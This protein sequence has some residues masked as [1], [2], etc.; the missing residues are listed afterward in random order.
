[1][2]EKNLKTLLKGL[3]LPDTILE[4]IEKPEFDVA[5]TVSAYNESQKAHY[6]DIIKNEIAPEI[7]DELSR[8][9]NGKWLGSLN[10]DLKKY[11]GVP[12]DEIKDLPVHEKLKLVKKKQDEAASKNPDSAAITKLQEEKMEWQN[13]HTELEQ[14]IAAK[15]ESANKDAEKR[16][17][18]K[19]TDIS[20]TK[21]FHSIPAEKIIGGH[22]EGIQLALKS[23]INTKYDLSVDEKDETVIFDKG[24]SKRATGKDA[25]GKEYFLTLDETM[26]NSLKELKL[27]K[28]SNGGEGSGNGGRSGEGSGNGQKKSEHMLRLEKAAAEAIKN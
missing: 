2:N 24:T 10:A 25:S 28:E 16:I 17:A 22:S 3:G 12:M 21:K 20:I 23:Y 11:F 15:I 27:Q 18:A 26:L 7:E 5:K 19:L 1:M 9:I 14:S 6:H 4:D 13:K 8:Q